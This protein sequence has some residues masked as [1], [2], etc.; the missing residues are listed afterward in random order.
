MRLLALL[1]VRNEIRYID[2]TL[3]HLVEQGAE[4]CVIDNGSTDGTREV[5]ERWLRNGVVR[6]EDQPWTGVF[7]L[8]TQLRIKERLAADE[9]A[10]WYVHVDADERRFAPHPYTS[11]IDG[12]ADVDQQG[13]NAVD[14]DE[15]V[16][17]PTFEDPSF[18]DQDLVS[19]MRWY[20]HYE[21]DSPDRLRTNAWRR[22]DR[23]DLV[24]TAGHHV[25]FPDQRV[26]PR[27]FV[28]R[29]YPILSADHALEKYGC[30]VFAA[31]ELAGSWHGD[32]ADFRAENLRLPHRAEL[33]EAGPD[34]DPDP[35]APWDRHPFLDRAA[36]PRAVPA[37]VDPDRPARRHALQDYARRHRAHI[38]GI[39][40]VAG[41][42]PRPRWSVMLPVHDPRPEHL[43][44]AL[45]SVLAQDPG[46]Q[47]EIVVVDDASANDVH[48]V[49]TAIGRGRVGYERHDGPRGLAGNWNAAV[50]RSRG[51]LV[52]LLHQ[53]DRVLP[54]FYDRIGRAL[55]ADPGLVAGYCRVS[56]IDDEGSVTWTQS[57]ERI[58]A[59]VVADLCAKEAEA[60]RMIIA[61]VVVRRST[62]EEIGGYRDDLPYCTDWDSPQARSPCSAPCGTSRSCSRTGVNTR[63]RSPARIQATGADLADRRRSIELTATLLPPELRERTASRAVR[64]SVVLA[65]RTAAEF[66]DA[67]ALDAAVAQAREILATLEQRAGVRDLPAPPDSMSTMPTTILTETRPTAVASPSSKPRS[68]AGSRPCGWRGPRPAGNDDDLRVPSQ[69]RARRQRGVRRRRSRDHRPANRR[70]LQPGSGGRPALAVD[71]RPAPR[72]TTLVHARVRRPMA[73][74]TSRSVSSNSWRCSSRRDSQT[75]STTSTRRSRHRPTMVGGPSH[76]PRSSASTTCRSCCSSTPSTT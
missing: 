36:G 26:F 51:E 68:R 3:A 73:V 14:F 34:E 52:H 65:A 32:R 62:Y 38:A 63:T 58:D 9:V 12:I 39:P 76:R 37:A 21:P 24:S 2:A 46:D 53:D 59:G 8:T 71:R 1:A 57:P 69:Q 44:E 67:D 74:P 23:V 16:F 35:A 6:I 5:A 22:H 29:H 66:V 60:H 18:E 7:E 49:V 43:A 45:R 55:V 19:A 64:S 13:W 30:R 28:M 47:M 75:R 31:D 41:D 72:S 17:V 50:A 61:G 40:A 25:R 15:F 54:G 11:L 27:P 33:R 20:Y 48:G 56:G 10:D 70:V 4:V 42:A